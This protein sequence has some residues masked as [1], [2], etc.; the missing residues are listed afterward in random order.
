MPAPTGVSMRVSTLASALALALAGV[1]AHALGLGGIRVQ[2]A[3]NQPFVGEIDLL[4]VRPDELDTVKVQI[5]RS[6]E[7][8][9]VGAERYNYLTKLRF[10][11]QISP[12]GNTVIRVSS[13]EPVREPYMD[14][15]VDVQWPKGR[16]VKEYTFLLDPPVTSA[17]SAPPVK[18][19][20][21]RA[22]PAPTPTASEPPTA[23]TP[24]PVPA[25]SARAPAPVPAPASAGGF[26][27]R[28]GPVRTGSG[29]WRLALKNS[30]RGATVAQT[31]MAL[32]RNNQGAFI[33]GDINRLLAGR[34]LVIPSSA[35][36]FALSPDAAQ[37]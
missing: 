5:A 6:E 13:R 8:S 15:L 2:S 35:E 28:V 4:D 34:T 37:S 7:F 3:L 18:Q 10:S 21:A 29:L 20:V 1:D 30:P 26:P 31:A 33:Q 24:N 9:R 19:P 36:L 12:R 17:R 23:R 16:L 27:L 25:V 14:F 22:R 11:P 32:Y